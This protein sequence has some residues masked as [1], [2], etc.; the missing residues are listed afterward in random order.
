MDV[1]RDV[2]L[3]CLMTANLC[4]GFIELT[5][6]NPLGKIY[7]DG[8]PLMENQASFLL[9]NNSSPILGNLEAASVTLPPY[10]TG[11][12][13]LQ[14]APTASPEE[15]ESASAEGEQ[16][17]DGGKDAREA[18]QDAQEGDDD[19][20]GGDGEDEG[21]SSSSS[22]SSE[23]ESES[24]EEK[25]ESV[26]EIG[27]VNVYFGGRPGSAI[28]LHLL[29]AEIGALPEPTVHTLPGAH[30]KQRFIELIERC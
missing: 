19:T 18:A 16:Q 15:G 21:N 3:I 22:S 7:E 24:S 6:A 1:T 20:T 13:A 23:S 12:N 30:G 14:T 8:V 4:A 27:A 29:A 2:I 10:E 9:V 11:Q 25:G 5:G 26:E 28:P 17:A